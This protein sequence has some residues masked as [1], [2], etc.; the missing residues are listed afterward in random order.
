MTVEEDGTIIYFL[1]IIHRPVFYLKATFWRLDS[2]SVLNEKP[3]QMCPID[4]ASPC[5]RTGTRWRWL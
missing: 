2:V 3:T 1:D 4:R 5:L